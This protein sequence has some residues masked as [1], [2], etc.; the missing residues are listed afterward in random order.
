MEDTALSDSAE[1]DGEEEDQEAVEQ[2]P[3]NVAKYETMEEYQT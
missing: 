3:A 2:S 1:E